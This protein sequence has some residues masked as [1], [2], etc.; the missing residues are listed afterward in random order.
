MLNF[1]NPKLSIP[2][3]R[4]EPPILSDF[5]KDLYQ[6]K[7]KQTF[8]RTRPKYIKGIDND[9]STKTPYDPY[10]SK[11]VETI[12][13]QHANNRQKYYK[14]RPPQDI[15]DKMRQI[16]VARFPHTKPPILMG[17]TPMYKKI[18]KRP[19]EIRGENFNDSKNKN[20]THIHPMTDVDKTVGPSVN[21]NRFH[22]KYNENEL[23]NQRSYREYMPKPPKQYVRQ[24]GQPK[25]GLRSRNPDVVDKTLVTGKKEITG[26]LSDAPNHNLTPFVLSR[27]N[28]YLIK[29][30]KRLDRWGNMPMIRDPEFVVSKLGDRDGYMSTIPTRDTRQTDRHK[31]L[32]NRYMGRH[33]ILY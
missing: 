23:H 8:R 9:Y 22:D 6:Y 12:A 1:L 32:K 15:T 3:L 14:K 25:Q 5:D 11:F 18:F 29:P 28:P 26:I 21:I 7:T 30:G 17:P 24:I 16:E 13:Y 31:I 4:N 33:K 10:N 19:E 2:L 20:M 27:I